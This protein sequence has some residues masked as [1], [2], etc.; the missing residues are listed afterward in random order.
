MTFWSV[1]THSPSPDSTR[2]TTSSSAVT[3]TTR[4]REGGWR[5]RTRRRERTTTRLDG[6]DGNDI[7]RG[8]SWLRP[9]RRASAATASTAR[10]MT[11]TC[12]ATT[13]TITSTPGAASTTWKGETKKNDDTLVSIDND[14][15]DI[16]WGQAGLEQLCGRQNRRWSGG[17]TPMWCST[18]IPTKPTIACTKSKRAFENGADKTLDG[19]DVAEPAGGVRWKDFRNKPLFASGGP[20][21]SDVRRGKPR[22]LLGCWPLSSLAAAA[23]HRPT[24]SVSWSSTWATAPSRSAQRESSTGSTPKRWPFSRR[25]PTISSTPAW[26]T[27]AL[28][29]SRP[30]EES[31]AMYRGNDYENMNNDI[32]YFPL[33]KIRAVRTGIGR[34]IR[35]TTTCWST[36][37]RWY[38]C[39]L[40]HGP[41][42]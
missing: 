15:A 1:T 3:A 22:R 40:L 34:S 12:S 36:W 4:F 28:P 38:R 29:G 10:R 42:R 23:A 20:T 6:G 9:A 8:D 35:T 39:G 16:L 14:D 31:Y 26:T 17:A 27:K 11:T 30:V 24:R 33:G 41:R 19:D 2:A 32:L 5:R 37:M 7:L 21:M 18:P 25:I 13:A